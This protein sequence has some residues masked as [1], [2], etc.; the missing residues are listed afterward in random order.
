MDAHLVP[1]V[2]VAFSGAARAVAFAAVL[3]PLR[4][5]VRLASAVATMHALSVTS[6]ALA[7]VAA[8]GVFRPYAIML[9]GACV[10]LF[11]PPAR[12]MLEVGS[13]TGDYDLARLRRDVLFNSVPF[14]A[15]ALAPVPLATGAAAPVAPEPLSAATTLSV[16]ALSLAVGALCAAEYEL[17]LGL[18]GFLMG[19]VLRSLV[20]LALFVTG[21]VP[22][23]LQACSLWLIASG[24]GALLGYALC[25]VPVRLSLGQDVDMEGLLRMGAHGLM[26]FHLVPGLDSPYR[27]AVRSA[28]LGVALLLWALVFQSL[29]C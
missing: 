19:P 16:A 28:A 20:P 4:L 7:A 21:V 29:V 1:L 17:G 23:T 15:L 6:M 25:Y 8:F 11:P 18:L 14:L 2:L 9:V 3:L 10:F 22:S 13:K 24:A 5:E 27:G 12:V 26:P